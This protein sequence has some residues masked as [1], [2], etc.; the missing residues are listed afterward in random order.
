MVATESMPSGV[1][2]RSSV[3]LPPPPRSPRGKGVSRAAKLSDEADAAARDLR[4]YVLSIY[5]RDDFV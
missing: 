5:N 1:E 2:S 3:E 4:I